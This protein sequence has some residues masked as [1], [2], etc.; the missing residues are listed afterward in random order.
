MPKYGDNDVLVRV[1]ATSIN[2]IDVKMR[3]GAAKSRFSKKYDIRVEAFM[4]QPD[5]S[6]LSQ[7]ADDVARREF[8]IP[9]VAR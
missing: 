7:L 6:R 2:P 4:A 5:A 9:R 3:S 8:S 1:R